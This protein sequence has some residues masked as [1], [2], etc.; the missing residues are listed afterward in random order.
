V[1]NDRIPDPV[2]RIDNFRDRSADV[3]TY[4]RIEDAR[5]RRERR[6]PQRRTP[7]PQRRSSEDDPD[8]QVGTR[9]DVRA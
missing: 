2:S 9:L 5:H 3:R 7:P 4:E 6:A 8:R 1:L